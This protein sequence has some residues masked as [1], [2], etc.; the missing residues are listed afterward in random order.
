MEDRVFSLSDK[1]IEADPTHKL[2][3]TKMQKSANNVFVRWN[4]LR[5]TGV[6][7]PRLI[8]LTSAVRKEISDNHTGFFLA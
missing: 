2:Y 5:E 8:E 6:L 7:S 3:Y 4:E 1:L